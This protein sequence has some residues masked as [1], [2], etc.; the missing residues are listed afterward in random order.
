[1][2]DSVSAVKEG[3]DLVIGFNPKL[4]T[5][6]IRV[7]DDEMITIYFVSSKTPFVI[8]NEEQTY[9]YLILPINF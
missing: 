7:I 9:T 6:A 1:M 2:V 4:V 5:D 8:R 3:S